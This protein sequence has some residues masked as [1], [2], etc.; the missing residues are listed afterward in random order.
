M[1]KPI[2][3]PKDKLIDRL[4]TESPWI[5]CLGVNICQLKEALET[6]FIFVVAVN[7]EDGSFQIASQ[8]ERQDVADMMREHFGA[9]LEEKIVPAMS[10]I[11]PTETSRIVRPDGRPYKIPG[12]ARKRTKRPPRKKHLER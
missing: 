6:P 11:A 4:A 12:A 9:I 2:N 1:N 3:E 7:P 8:S 5:Q 10:A